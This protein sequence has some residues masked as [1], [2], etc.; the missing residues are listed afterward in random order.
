MG[1]KGRLRLQARKG[2]LRCLRWWLGWLGRFLGWLAGGS[3]G[4][5]G[6]FLGWLGR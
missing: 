5:L 4:R 6:R 2:F 1:L 3:W